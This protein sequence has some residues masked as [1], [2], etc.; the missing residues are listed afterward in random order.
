M[1]LNYGGV[2]LYHSFKA[3]VGTHFLFHLKYVFLPLLYFFR[4]ATE[5]EQSKFP[6]PA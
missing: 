2:Y 3:A 5:I 1:M 6:M 4:N